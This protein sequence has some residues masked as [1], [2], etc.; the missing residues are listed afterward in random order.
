M[1]CHEW[2]RKSAAGEAH[3]PGMH[4]WMSAFTADAIVKARAGV[5]GGTRRASPQGRVARCSARHLFL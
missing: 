3:I 2:A 4:E 1:V 5:A